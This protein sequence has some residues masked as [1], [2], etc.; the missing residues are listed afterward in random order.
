MVCK[1]Q[2]LKKSIFCSRQHIWDSEL[3][4]VHEVY[5]AEAQ[6][7]GV[8]SEASSGESLRENHRGLLLLIIT[9]TD[10]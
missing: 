2:S 3:V 9:K 4:M 6:L 1:C 10:G 5:H 8:F 7:V